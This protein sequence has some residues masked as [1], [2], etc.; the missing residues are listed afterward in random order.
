MN[1]KINTVLIVSLTI[2]FVLLSVAFALLAAPLI[3][4]AAESNEQVYIYNLPLVINQPPLSQNC[5]EYSSH[6]SVSGSEIFVELGIFCADPWKDIPGGLDDRGFNEPLNPEI[7]IVSQDRNI[8]TVSM[9][10]HWGICQI[11][12]GIPGNQYGDYVMVSDYSQ[13]D[14]HTNFTLWYDGIMPAYDYYPNVSIVDTVLYEDGS[15]LLTM[16]IDAFDNTCHQ[17]IGYI[18]AIRLTLWRNQDL[19]IQINRKTE[20]RGS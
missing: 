11:G 4:S 14:N 5:E 3:V 19:T 7:T 8:I 9:C 15:M 20:K 16:C 17:I 1:T 6:V 12:D 18:C 2:M 10:L 13:S